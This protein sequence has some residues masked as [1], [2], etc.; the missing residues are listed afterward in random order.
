MP[1][2]QQRNSVTAVTREPVPNPGVSVDIRD[3]AN[4]QQADGVP[5]RPQRGRQTVTRA[6]ARIVGQPPPEEI[7]IY[8]DYIS[9]ATLS[10]LV[11]KYGFSNTSAVAVI[12]KKID[13]WLIPQFMGDIR[14]IKCQHTERLLYIVSEAMG[15]WEKSKWDKIQFEH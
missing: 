14:E 10:K 12:V 11:A 3:I 1:T 8:A 15:A 2:K 7:A 9:G 5:K 6:R 13:K 4:K